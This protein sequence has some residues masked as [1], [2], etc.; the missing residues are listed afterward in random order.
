MPV[1][2]TNEDYVRGVQQAGGIALLV[3]PGD[4]EAGLALFDQ[5]QGLLL[6]GGADV[7]P[8]RYGA[9][10]SPKLGRT[11]P[12]RDALEFALL[13]RAVQR[14]IPVFGICRGQQVINAALGGTL[15]QDLASEHPSDLGHTTPD[16]MPRDYIAHS[17]DVEPRTYLAHVVGA[18]QLEVNSFHHQAIKDLAPGLRATAFSP[19]GI[20][21]GVESVD[22]RILAVQCHPE[23]LMRLHWARAL[24]ER[25][26]RLC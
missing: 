11:E 15:Y 20:V 16:G 14:N 24:F 13:G 8:A 18:G 3:P 25:F 12:D 10:P 23:E 21:E 22:G 6:T 5:A 4:V 17:I 9:E 2:G 1:L 7:D 19:D 26:I